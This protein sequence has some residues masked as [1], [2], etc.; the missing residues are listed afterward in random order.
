MD[1][2]VVVVNVGLLVDDPQ[3]YCWNCCCCYLVDCPSSCCTGLLF[4]LM[5]ILVVGDVELIDSILADQK[6]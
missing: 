1:D 4:L 2:V 6:N 3:D 5:I